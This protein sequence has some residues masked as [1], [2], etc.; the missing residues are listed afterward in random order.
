MIGMFLKDR[1]GATAIE[2]GLIAALIA[3][4]ALGAMQLTGGGV[5]SLYDSNQEQISDAIQNV[6]D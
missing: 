4:A 2:Y 1:T 5:D 6:T 3:V